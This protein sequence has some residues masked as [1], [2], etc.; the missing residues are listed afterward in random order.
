MQPCI[1]NVTFTG[2]SAVLHVMPWCRGDNRS[3]NKG[4]N[5]HLSQALMQIW[6]VP[7]LTAYKWDLHAVVSVGSE[8]R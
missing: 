8:N 2:A 1:S 5:S 4:Q 6:L 7:L 3:C